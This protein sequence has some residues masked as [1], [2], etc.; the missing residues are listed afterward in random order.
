[1][2]LHANANADCE[3]WLVELGCRPQARVKVLQRAKVKFLTIVIYV[4]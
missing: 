4:I 1:M 2:T 3:V